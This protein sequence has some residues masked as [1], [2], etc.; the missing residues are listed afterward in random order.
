MLIMHG[1]RERNLN[2]FKTLLDASG[3]R[4]TSLTPTSTPFVLI[5]AVAI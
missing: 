5:E 4:F 1:G 3:F 2:E